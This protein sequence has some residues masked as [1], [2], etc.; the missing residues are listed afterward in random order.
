[1]VFKQLKEYEY[2]HFTKLLI[3]NGHKD[4]LDASFSITMKV[5]DGEYIIK[6]Q[7]SKK[8]RIYALQALV[9][10]RSKNEVEMALN[11]DNVL[12]LSLLNI[13]LYQGV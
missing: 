10:Y 2:N 3:Q 6:I 7:P 12:L 5:N 1:M 9:V 11:T 4:G 8:L 13:L